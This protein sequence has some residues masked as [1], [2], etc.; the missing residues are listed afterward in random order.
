MGIFLHTVLFPGGR[1]EECREA[2]ARCGA[3]PQLG[4]RPADCRW[5]QC[6]RG[7][8]VLLNDGFAGAELL[9]ARLSFRLEY[10]LMVLFLYDGDFW[11][12]CLWQKGA[13]LDRF[14]SLPDYFG[15]G[16]PPAEPGDAR[17]VG[18]VFSKTPAL[19]Q[20]YL[21][22][23]DEQNAGRRAYAGDGAAAG[24]CWQMADFMGALGFDYNLFAIE[25]SEKASLS[26]DEPPRLEYQKEAWLRRG[27]AAPEDTPE[28]PNVL[29]D[30]D[31]ALKRAK[32][33]GQAGEAILALLKARE[34]QRGVD[35]LTKAVQD[36]PEEPGFYLLRAFCWSQMEGKGQGRSRKPDMDR[37]LTKALETE[38]DNVRILRAR[39]PTV[40]TSAR[41]QRHIQDLTRLIALDPE[42][43]DIYLV[44]RAY[45]LHWSGNDNGARQDLELVL[46]HGQLWTVD[47]TYLCNE[48]RLGI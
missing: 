4:L 6:A 33:L 37:D 42:N 25:P 43:Q 32:Q 36:R 44:A 10:P 48:L 23:W 34:Y 7:P 27:P 39:C 16:S 3:D 26:G 15:P 28:L 2:L 30:R 45:R 41:Y 22:P 9:A 18:R 20:N 14:S 13:E 35:W 21:E 12:Y 17:A 29:N 5:R 38:P 40:A 31:Y 24:D 47:L 8:A 46:R 11:G 1:E 19:L